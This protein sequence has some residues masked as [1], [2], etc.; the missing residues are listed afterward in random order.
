MSAAGVVGQVHDAVMMVSIPVLL[1]LPYRIGMEIRMASA[2]WLKASVV[3][4]GVAANHVDGDQVW[5]PRFTGNQ[6]H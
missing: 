5:G 2:G 6:A 3:A 1:P 4:H